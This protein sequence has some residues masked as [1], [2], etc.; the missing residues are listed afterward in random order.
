MIFMQLKRIRIYN[1]EGKS[2][3]CM[4]DCRL[5]VYEGCAFIY[6]TDENGA[7]AY[8]GPHKRVSV[9]PL[10]KISSMECYEKD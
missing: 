2:L 3:F 6:Y 8:P 5:E 7:P 10:N 9:F 1:E 4:S